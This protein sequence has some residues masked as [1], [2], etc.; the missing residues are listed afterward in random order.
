M[1]MHAVTVCSRTNLKLS[2]LVALSEACA[3]GMSPNSELI[4]P[5]YHLLL[6]YSVCTFFEAQLKFDSTV[7]VTHE[8]LGIFFS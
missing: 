8:C 2:S 5:L 7:Y 3:G 4:V 1:L 6:H